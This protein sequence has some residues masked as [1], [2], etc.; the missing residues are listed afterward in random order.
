MILDMNIQDLNIS[1][2]AKTA[3]KSIGLTKVSEL[4]GQNYITLIDKFPKNFN[5]EP[6]INELNTL[7][8]LLPP[9]GEISVYDVSMSKRLQNALIQNGV[10]YLS[11]LSSYPKEKIL[12]F[13]NLGEKTAIELEQICR[14]YHI[15]IRSM[16]SIKEYFDKY[17][18]PAKIYPMLFQCD[19]SCLNDFK[20]KTANDLY[21]IC[22][23]DYSLTMRIYF[24]LRENGI[25]FN[26]WQD[27]YIFEVLPEKNAT[28]L[29]KKYKISLLSQIPACDE[30]EL[31]QRISSSNSFS[32]A[33]KD[34]LSIG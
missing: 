28:M 2:A 10:M 12:H 13:R 31:R 17:Q 34:L 5:L 4:E 32:V 22:Q 24:I 1:A 7:G 25:V 3:L 19:I 18:F 8:F 27:K 29:W 9:S 30:R 15:E 11:Q 26:N 14:A 33:I 20:N 6:I 21:H 23:E 16:A